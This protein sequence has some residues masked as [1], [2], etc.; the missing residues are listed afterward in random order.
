MI[1]KKKIKN[2]SEKYKTFRSK[3]KKSTVAVYILLRLAVLISL[4]FN[5]LQG[6]FENVFMCLLTLILFLI[7]FIA[8]ET[9]EVDI[10]PFM[11]IIML[12]FIFSAEILGEIES[13]YL[14]I[15]YWDTML[16]TING[17]LMGA[18]GFAMIDLFNRSEKFSLKLTPIFVVFTAFCFSMTTGVV[19]EFFEYGLDK[20]TGT[21]CQKDVWVD[22]VNTVEFDQTKSN[23][24]TSIDIESVVVNGEKWPG[25][26]DIGLIDTMKDM[27]VNLIGAVVFSIIGFIVLKKRDYDK[28]N[29][30]LIKKREK[31]IAT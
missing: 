2:L 9:F 19:W 13:F 15:P 3:E 18:I 14:K 24:V 21:D 6:N 27:F 4:I 10:P 16:H 8:E 26:L 22:Y 30:L 31:E 28:I 7:P 1:M 23:T 5:F 20:F 17:F 25:Y 11:Q 12:L 29:H